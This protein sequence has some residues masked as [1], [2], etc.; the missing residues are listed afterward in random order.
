MLVVGFV[1]SSMV[2]VHAEETASCS[3][4]AASYGDSPR[5]VSVAHLSLRDTPSM[6]GKI[7]QFLDANSSFRVVANAP[8]TWKKICLENGVVGYLNSKFTSTTPVYDTVERK[9]LMVTAPR[10]FVRDKSLLKKVAVVHK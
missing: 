5:Y 1:S 4:D 9:S 3:Q 2:L 7:I 8:G 10:A 6:R